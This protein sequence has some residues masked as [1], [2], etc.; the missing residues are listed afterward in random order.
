MSI[1]ITEAEKVV[2]RDFY[3]KKIDRLQE[4]IKQK[5]EEIS[6]V[7]FRLSVLGF[8]DLFTTIEG[9]KEMYSTGWTMARKAE[10][11]LEQ[12]GK[13]MAIRE[14]VHDICKYEAI[15]YSD[16]EGK[17]MADKLAST[18]KQKVDKGEVFVRILDG[19]LFKYGLKKWVDN[20]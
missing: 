16:G 13:Y 5:E 11:A 14:I 15:L 9:I 3:M 20:K 7:V 10:Y 17:E 18:L 1:G 8:N 4:E 2:L 19:N 12:A 6:D